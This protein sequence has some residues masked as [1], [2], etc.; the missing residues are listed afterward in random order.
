VHPTRWHALS[1]T[2][3]V[4][5]ISVAH[6]HP[7]LS[8]K[9]SQVQVISSTSGVFH[10]LAWVVPSLTGVRVILAAHAPPHPSSESEWVQVI[11]TPAVLPDFNAT[12]L[13]SA[14]GAQLK[15][16]VDQMN[17]TASRKVLVKSGKVN[18]LRQ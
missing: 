4:C 10:T 17:T 2:T 8:S 6:T 3:G 1:L 15:F 12:S 7:H 5:S 18:D 9:S 13:S 11:S 14:T 16:W